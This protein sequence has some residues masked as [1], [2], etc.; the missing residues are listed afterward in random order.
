MHM[1]KERYVI[2][3]PNSDF[4]GYRFGVKFHQGR[5]T[6]TSKEVRDTLVKDHGYREVAEKA[7]E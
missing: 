2:E 3:V 4:D 1:A 5:A 7:E 6:V